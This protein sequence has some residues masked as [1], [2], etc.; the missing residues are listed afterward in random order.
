[1]LD[2]HPVLWLIDNIINLLMITI[3]VA[4]VMSWLVA[5]DVINL[6]NRFVRMVYDTANAIMEPFLR[7]IR[8]II[9]VFGGL[10]LSPLILLI[11][12][13]FAQRLIYWIWGTFNI[14]I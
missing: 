12:L 13:G 3:F 2:S 11:L 8:R 6:R 1:M 9:P 4:V 14:P 7:P 10:D 5:F